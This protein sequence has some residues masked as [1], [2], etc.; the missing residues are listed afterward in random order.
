MK[1]K[2]EKELEEENSKITLDEFKEKVNLEIVGFDTSE[3]GMEL[4]QDGNGFINFAVGKS[5]Y[6]QAFSWCKEQGILPFVIRGMK[7]EL[8]LYRNLKM[9]I[10]YTEEDKNEL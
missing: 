4:S 5:H 6:E 7:V 2:T 10:N 1:T 9:I 8:S 3:E